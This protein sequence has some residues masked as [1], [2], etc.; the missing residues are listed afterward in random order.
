MSLEWAYADWC[1]AQMAQK[2]GKIAIADSF[3][4]RAN[5]Y[6]RLFDT[7]TLFIRPRN[8]DGSWKSPFDPASFNPN[9]GYV[10]GN[11]WQYLWSV[12]HDVEG[13]VKLLKGK[14]NA[15]QR[16]DS[17]FMA[18][19]LQNELSLEPLTG[20]IGYCAM[21][22]EPS[23]HIP[24]MYN[25]VSQPWKTQKLVNLIC[26][27]SYRPARSG[28]PGNDDCGQTS[29]W[30][31]F[32]A[33]GFYP[34]NGASLQYVIGTPMFE[35][36]SIDVGN[37]KKFVVRAKGISRYNYYIQSASLNGKPFNLPNISHEAIMQGGE[38]V[39]EMGSKPSSWGL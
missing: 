12:M 3:I 32:S 33:I 8:S 16:L 34:V 24:Y 18:P 17:L 37:N 38:L 9:D 7:T 30:Y 36:T 11:A 29:A 31:V 28:L 10:E 14:W 5:S 4:W 25:F 15:S 2:M 26:T 20:T 27:N 35:E 23:H 13:L 39:F 19:F 22:N 1:I 21:A 6:Q